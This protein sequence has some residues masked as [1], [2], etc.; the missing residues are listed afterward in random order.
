MPGSKRTPGAT[1]EQ[2]DRVLEQR[3]EGL[4][5]SQLL[6]ALSSLPEPHRRTLLLFEVEGFSVREIA[7]MVG[8]PPGTV[9]SRLHR[10]RRT[11]RNKLQSAPST[12]IS[13]VAL[14]ACV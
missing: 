12:A 1:S 10:G 14:E 7:S 8:V 5:R 3:E 4:V 11:L 6:R 9:M 2:P 13:R